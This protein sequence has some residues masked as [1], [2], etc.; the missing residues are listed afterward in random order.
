MMEGE[1]N[2]PPEKILLQKRRTRERKRL[3][4]ICATFM[5]A[6][7]RFNTIDVKKGAT[8]EG[9]IRRIKIHELLQTSG[10]SSVDGI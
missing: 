6:K 3:S 4:L 5:L 9:N 10:F 8:L 7:S 1:V 2:L